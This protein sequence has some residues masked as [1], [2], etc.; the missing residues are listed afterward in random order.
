[1]D[2]LPGKPLSLWVDRLA[3]RRF[4]ALRGDREFDVVV[5]GAGI[6]GLSAA[7]RL[8]RAGRRVAVIEML[9]VGG[10][11]TGRSTA[12]VTAQHG[13]IYHDLERRLGRHAARLY[14]DAQAAGLAEIADHV[15]RHRIA[16]GFE[17]K[18]AHLF[19]ARAET[20]ERLAA[21]A[22][23]ARRAGLP[24]ELVRDVPLPV[25]AVA[26]LR[27]ADQAQFDPC[28]YLAHLAAEVDGGGS[29][30]FEDTRVT[31]VLDGEPCAVTAGGFTVKAA[32]VVVASHLPVVPDGAFHKKTTPRAH[33]V[34]A[35]PLERGR[36]PDGMFLGLD[37]PTHSIRGADG[38]RTL[39][40]AGPSYATGHGGN[41]IARVREIESF[42]RAHFPIGPVSHHW[43][44]E[45]Y[46][47]QD[48]LPFVG[49]AAKDSRH[50]W[51]ATGFGAW[52]FTNGAAAGRILGDALTGRANPWAELFDA[53]REPAEVAGGGHA[54]HDDAGRPPRS[55]ADLA[56][57]DGAVFD[58]GEEKV[59]VWKDEAGVSHALSATCTHL[60]C[61]VAW[62]PA[63]RT[64]DCHCHGSVFAADGRVLHG[65][66][67]GDLKAHK[68]P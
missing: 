63:E 50:L 39:V 38:G 47:S 57:G 26:A 6:A 56:P 55:P 31:A 33:L 36:A 54:H 66:A 9:R 30:V 11:V 60:G 21:E 62:N 52:G 53:T 29:A 41:T 48:R 37:A 34:I 16:C 59:A 5:V 58:A 43:G 3:A 19:T 32:D 61:P 7:L 67:V 44:N 2:L 1:M 64:W 23:A 45:D 4:P 10:Q 25:P 20:V 49:R 42:A 13:L 27:F 24:A 40:V 35:A 68:L 17:R 14:A 46:D 18:A 12:K 8:K 65:P 15:H 51:V 22:D 28:P